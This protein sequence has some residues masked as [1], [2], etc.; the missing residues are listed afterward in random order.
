MVHG[1]AGSH[2]VPCSQSREALDQVVVDR[3]A[4]TDQ[5]E[6]E[7]VRPHVPVAPDRGDHEDDRE[8]VHRDALVPAQ[9]ARRQ[10]G[11]FREVQRADHRGA[12]DDRRDAR[13]LSPSRVACLRPRVVARGRT[14][15][16][17]ARTHSANVAMFA[18][19]V[20]TTKKL[21]QGSSVT[22]AGAQDDAGFTSS[23]R[24]CRPDRD[25]DG[26][27]GTRPCAP[28][29]PPRPRPTVRCSP[30]PGGLRPVRSSSRRDGGGG[31]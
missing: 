3:D 21:I 4:R 12:G 23:R 26:G 18:P 13:P 9:A 8:R 7:R 20:R 5:A 2:D 14:A 17:S 16:R 1:F 6:R 25:G 11:A 28:P 19:T 10:V 24:T 22:R 27:C 29:A 31:R 15:R 30:T